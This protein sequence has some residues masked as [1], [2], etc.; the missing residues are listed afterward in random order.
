MPRPPRHR[1]SACPPLLLRA[2]VVV[3]V[4]VVLALVMERAHAL[5]QQERRQHGSGDRREKGR[6]VQVRVVT[7]HMDEGRPEHYGKHLSLFL[8]FFPQQARK[9]QGL[10]SNILDRSSSNPWKNDPTLPV[11]AAPTPAP[12]RAPTIAR[13]ARPTGA[14]STLVMC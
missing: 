10:I 2:L 13:T 8:P 3:V 6:H 12:T 1:S 14:Y 7:V 11:T 4:V 5:G 9:G